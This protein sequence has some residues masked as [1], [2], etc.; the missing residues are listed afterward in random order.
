MFKVGDKVWSISDGWG[1][2]VLLYSKDNTIRV[3]FKNGLAWFT[4]DGKGIGKSRRTLFFEER[5]RKSAEEMLKEC[6]EIEFD[7]CKDNYY[8]YHTAVAVVKFGS[9][10]KYKIYGVKYISKDDAERIVLECKENN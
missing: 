2:V 1:I 7:F 8:I 9:N 10:W 5:P 3:K 4:S 6:E